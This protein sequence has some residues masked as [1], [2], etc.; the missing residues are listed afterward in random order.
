MRRAVV[1]TLAVAAAPSHARDWVVDGG[2]AAA[3]DSGPGTDAT[4]LK[5]IGAA[6]KAAQAGDRVVV[7]DGGSGHV[8]RERV[9]PASGDVVYTAAP[10]HHPTVRGSEPLP[11]ASWTRQR[12][13]QQQGVWA[14]ALG[15][16][17]F[18]TV[19]GGLFNPY[20]IR[21][22]FPGNES[23]AFAGASCEGGHTLGQVFQS[24]KL[25]KEVSGAKH[26]FVCPCT[27]KPDCTGGGQG[28][29]GTY[30]YSC[31]TPCGQACGNPCGLDVN[32]S[33]AV[34]DDDTCGCS[35]AGQLAGCCNF[36]HGLAHPQL[37]P[38]SWMAVKNGTEI[39]ARFGDDTSPPSGVE[40]TV[41]KSVFSPHQ[42]GLGNVTVRGF[43]LE[44]AAN[45]WDDF[46]WIARTQAHNP[47]P[48]AFAQGGLLSTRSGHD[49]LV[50]Q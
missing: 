6:A 10:G 44:H 42:R 31:G 30:K 12:G 32:C 19:A 7:H 45:Q 9:A 1:V 3:S 49:W 35:H 15:G 2:S 4:P 38:M 24:G 36:T 20:A 37:A 43:V 13:P 16:L 11:A 29:P 41:R 8:Y 18:E 14:A 25:L 46:F 33:R 47:S 48:A 39:W 5:T 22:A 26:N 34:C 28:C 21:L 23:A 50:E 17:P 40:V 27:G